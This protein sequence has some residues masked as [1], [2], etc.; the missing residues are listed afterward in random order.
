MGRQLTGIGWPQGSGGHAV[1]VAAATVLWIGD[2]IKILI[3]IAITVVIGAI[4]YFNTAV[5]FDALWH[6][7]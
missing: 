3:N 5:G 4:A 6:S 2:E 7:V 1:V